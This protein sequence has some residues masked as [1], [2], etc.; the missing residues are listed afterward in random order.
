MEAKLREY[1][2][3]SIAE[4]DD[5]PEHSRIL[6]S[7]GYRQAL[8]DIARDFFPTEPELWRRPE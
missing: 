4:L 6:F 1:L 5:I 7:Y 3:H 2:A 8:L